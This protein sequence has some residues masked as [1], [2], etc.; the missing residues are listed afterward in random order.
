VALVVAGARVPENIK[1][2]IGSFATGSFAKERLQINDMFLSYARRNVSVFIRSGVA[3]VTPNLR[4]N[5][6]AAHLP[7]L[8]DSQVVVSALNHAERVEPVQPG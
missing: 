1:V 2:Q 3:V 7:G 6:K 5:L 8:A 4:P